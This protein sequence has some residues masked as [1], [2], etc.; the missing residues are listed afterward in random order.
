MTGGLFTTPTSL[1]SIAAERKKWL[2]G[3][4]GWVSFDRPYANFCQ[5]HLVKRPA[6]VGSGEFLHW[7]FPLSYWMEQQGY[8]VSYIS[9]VD[10]HKDGPGLQRAKGFIS[11]GHDEYWTREMY[12]NAI[13]ARDAGVNLAFLSGNAVNGAVPLLP[14]AEGQ[15]DYADHPSRGR[16]QA[17]RG[18]SHG[19]TPPRPRWWRLGLLQARSLAV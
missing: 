10:T 8:D 19:W 11:V 17:G 3:P 9:N 12:D 15:P 13:A 2:T 6:S 5:E 14:S 16:L 1:S 18:T 7:E 4:T